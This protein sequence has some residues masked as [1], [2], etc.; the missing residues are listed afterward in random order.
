MKTVNKI[1]QVL[2]IL[3]GLA[4]LVLFCLSFAKLTIS[5]ETYTF[6]GA[7]LAFGT[8]KEIADG[9]V[10]NMAMSAD[11]LF[12]MVL[13]FIGIICSGFAFKSKGCKYAA[14]GF[15]LGTAIY[16]LVV[17]LSSAW[18]F[19]DTRADLSDAKFDYLVTDVKYTSFVLFIV[20]ALFLFA[21][22]AIADLLIS[23]A[24][25]VAESKGAKKPIFK[26]IVLF[27][28]DYK[29]EAKKIVWPTL[30]DVLKNTGIVL[31]MCLLIGA[32]IWLVDLGLGTL[33]DWILGLKS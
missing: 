4:T 33:L 21:A 14:S 5:G 30:R 3:F 26:R 1:C 25:E 7:Q 23:D 12:C 16:M 2:A 18:K 27:F 19:V 31:I 28:R 15:A 6:T 24:I 9:V 32:L 10:A 29:S 22:A 11:V 20:I 8:S 17:R 13:T